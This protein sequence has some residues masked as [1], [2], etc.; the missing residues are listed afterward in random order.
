MSE[1]T[2][3]QLDAEAAAKA[4]KQADK[5]AKAA[6]AAE[7]KAAKQA[8]REAKKAAAEA[9]KEA[10]K[11]EREAAK[12]AK[13]D[14]KEAAK[15]AKEAEKAAKEQA[16]ADAKAA[17]EASRQPEQNGIRRPGPE[18]LCG[19]VWGLADSLSQQLGQAVPIANLLEAGAAAGLNPSNI[20]TEY[21][22]WKKFHGLSGRITL[23]AAAE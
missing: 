17:K 9:E 8:E 6:A 21:A 20:R 3:E 13:I 16:K 22:R 1:K 11:A 7:A 5:E 23:P 2:Q 10:G 4:Q 19:Q 14:A 18:G 15:A 12:Q